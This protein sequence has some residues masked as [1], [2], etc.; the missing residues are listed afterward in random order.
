MKQTSYSIIEGFSI[1]LISLT[2]WVFT[3]SLQLQ[4][5]IYHFFVHVFGTVVR[6]IL[7]FIDKDRYN[8][9]VI[10]QEQ[11][12]SMQELEILFQVSKVKN[13]VLTRGSWTEEHSFMLINCEERLSTECNWSN[14]RI[15]DYFKSVINEIPGVMY[16]S[17]N[18]EDDGTMDLL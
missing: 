11:S 15:N 17:T 18:I 2:Q 3:K 4:T 5:Q 1:F 6:W 12:M 8:H 13:D 16:A 14:K 7:C 10:V 9:A